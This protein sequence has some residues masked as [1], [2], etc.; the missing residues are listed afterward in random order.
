MS[1]I[2]VSAHIKN[3][4]NLGNVNLNFRKLT[5]IVGANSSG[6][7]CSLESL[8]L[9]NLLVK[10]GKTPSSA[11]L[12]ND[13]RKGQDIS[14][15]TI[16][17]S[18]KENRT[19]VNYSL[20][21]TAKDNSEESSVILSEKLKV[22]RIEVISIHNGEGTVQDESTNVGHSKQSYRATPNTVALSSSGNF[23][24][25]PITLNIANF[26]RRWGFY[27]LD[28]DS[29]RRYAFT[30]LRNEAIPEN[31]TSLD[32]YGQH[33][34][35]LL[36]HWASDDMQIF[37]QV[38]DEVRRYVD[39][40]LVAVDYK[41]RLVVKVKEP[42]GLEIPFGNLSDGTLRMIGYC[43][44]L[45]SPDIPTLIAIE[46]PERNLHPGILEDVASILKRLSQKTQVVIT[47]HSSQ[48]LDCFS[49]ED[50]STNVSVILFR[51]N[52][53]TGTEAIGL[54]TLSQNNDGLQDWMQD[55]GIG[56]AIY[57]STLIQ[58]MLGN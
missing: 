19:K 52:P 48:L 28:P 11:Y 1:P 39:V 45:Y 46:E 37:Q 31:P 53:K 55:F 38:S 33:L 18:I 34:Q 51:K 4:K 26:I 27:D 42:N 22:G 17:V 25:K 57:H 36:Q 50:I 44:L 35:G 54:D 21:L 8:N 29:I 58:E 15:I 49:M 56:S 6:K 32:F 9:L 20:N 30:Y 5:I 14:G 7:S 2:L 16:Q 47:T 23:G 41:G 40:D 43:S 3:Y 10:A 12:E 13:I 24:D